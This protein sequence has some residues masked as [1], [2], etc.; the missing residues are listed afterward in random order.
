MTS[1]VESKTN[2]EVDRIYGAALGAYK[3]QIDEAA[4]KETQLLLDIDTYKDKVRDL[5]EEDA[6]IFKELMAREKEIG[7]GLVYVKTGAKI[8]EKTMDVIAN[9]QVRLSPCFFFLLFFLFLRRHRSV[10]HF[11]ASFNRFIT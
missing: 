2:E 10:S 1:D 8:S 7:I 4:L 9:R 5:K 3:L 6:R 11:H